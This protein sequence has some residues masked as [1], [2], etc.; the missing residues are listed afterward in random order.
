MSNKPDVFVVMRHRRGCRPMPAYQGC[1]YDTHSQAMNAM[2]THKQA[3]RVYSKSDAREVYVKQ[4]KS[5]RV[6]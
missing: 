2:N 5:R 4:T 6:R 3:L 1:V